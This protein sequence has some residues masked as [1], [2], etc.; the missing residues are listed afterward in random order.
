MPH[1][2]TKVKRIHFGAFGVIISFIYDVF[3]NYDANSSNSLIT[4]NS[5]QH[6]LSLH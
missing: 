1:K 6:R 5:V 2:S 3:D 4:Q